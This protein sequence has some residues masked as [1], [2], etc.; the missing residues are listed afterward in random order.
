[1][2][3]KLKIPA[4]ISIVIVYVFSVFFAFSGG[5]IYHIQWVRYENQIK[6][7]QNTESLEFS[8]QEW[9]AFSDNKEIKYKD[10]F[11]DIISVQTLQ[12]RVIVKVVKDN[13]ENKL[14]LA[15]LKLFNKNKSSNSDDNKFDFFSKHILA[16]TY[17]KLIKESNF[18]L[19]TLQ[20]FVSVFQIKPKSFITILQKPPC[21]N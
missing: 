6:K 2:L 7:L 19:D 17:T 13:L 10:N 1:M 8:N 21:C 14:N 16:S 18:L 15:F 3:K 9:L 5:F 12:S 20:N 4:I 11:Y